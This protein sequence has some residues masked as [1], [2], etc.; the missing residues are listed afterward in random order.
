MHDL[1]KAELDPT[2]AAGHEDARFEIT[3]RAAEVRMC[4]SQLHVHVTKSS[5]PKST[6]NL[7]FVAVC[8]SV[9]SQP[10][11]H[12]KWAN[13]QMDFRACSAT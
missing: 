1:E 3:S 9:R 5:N 2:L 10:S 13:V 4:S 8:R 12:E 11:Y 6:T 7:L